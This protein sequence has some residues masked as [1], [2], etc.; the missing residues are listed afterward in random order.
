MQPDLTFDEIVL[1]SALC[2]P[3]W[4]VEDHWGYLT[5]EEGRCATQE[6]VVA[7]LRKQGLL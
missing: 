1:Q 3:D 4:T 2:H 7:S 6:A 5:Y